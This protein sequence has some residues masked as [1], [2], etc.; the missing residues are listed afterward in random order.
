LFLTNNLLVLKYSK[1]PR[2]YHACNNSNI[3]TSLALE[4]NEQVHYL[5]KV[6]RVN[7][8]DKIRIFNEL[9]GEYIC[10]I[11]KTSP[12]QVLVTPVEHFRVP[13]VEKPSINLAVGLVKKDKMEFIAEKATE[14][15]IDSLIPLITDRVQNNFKLKQ[16]RLEKLAAAATCQSENFKVPAISG[17]AGLEEFLANHQD[18]VIILCDENIT[19]SNM[20]EKINSEIGKGVKISIII[21]PEGGFS[22]RELDMIYRSGARALSLGSS[23]LKTETAAI[24]AISIV[25]FITRELEQES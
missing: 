2:L 9:S 10:V 20:L 5:T 22:S 12:R 24:S 1:L 21:G 8:G 6:L 17:L 23:V 15:G 11:N 3:D 7:P 13:G 18:Q 14:L 16:D 4:Q 19:T 25:K